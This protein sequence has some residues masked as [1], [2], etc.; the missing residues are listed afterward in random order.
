MKRREIYKGAHVAHEAFYGIVTDAVL[1]RRLLRLKG[2]SVTWELSHH[3]VTH[4]KPREA[5]IFR[6]VLP[7]EH[8]GPPA[9]LGQEWRWRFEGGRWTWELRYL[10]WHDP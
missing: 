7:G 10:P 3:P 1:S 8:M 4:H 6:T 5:A 9:P 2:F